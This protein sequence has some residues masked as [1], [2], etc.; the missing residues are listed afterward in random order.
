ME[1]SVKHLLTDCVIAVTAVLMADGLDPTIFPLYPFSRMF[2]SKII[3][4][5]V[6]IIRQAKTEIAL[7]HCITRSTVDEIIIHF[8]ID[9]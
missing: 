2:H 7:H 9:T 8:K 1:V 3:I 5:K 4:S 6:S